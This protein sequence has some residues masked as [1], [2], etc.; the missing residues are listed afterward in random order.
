[1]ATAVISHRDARMSNQR[2]RGKLVAQSVNVGRS[3]GW[4]PEATEMATAVISHWVARKT[5]RQTA[6]VPAVNMGGSQIILSGGVFANVLRTLQ[7]FE[8]IIRCLPRTD[9][10][11]MIS[12]FCLQR[13]G[14]R[15]ATCR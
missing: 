1:M 9:C 12:W 13:L 10:H 15:S 5:Y 2:Q 6:H 3:S 8:P 14:V 11:L 4:L 7:S